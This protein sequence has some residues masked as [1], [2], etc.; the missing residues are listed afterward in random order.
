MVAVKKIAK[1]IFSRPKVATPTAKT[2]ARPAAI[3]GQPMK[4]PG[5]NQA[6]IQPIK[7]ANATVASPTLMGYSDIMAMPT[8][9]GI[10]I[11]PAISPAATSRPHTAPGKRQSRLR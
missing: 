6:L 4:F 10:A 1:A 2:G 5:L 7:Q 3:P 11:D 9:S 8:V